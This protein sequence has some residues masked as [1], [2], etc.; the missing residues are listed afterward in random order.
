MNDAAI[1]AIA[2][3]SPF[4]RNEGM[5]TSKPPS[6]ATTPPPSRLTSTGVPSRSSMTATVYAPSPMK[7]A[8]PRLTSPV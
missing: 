4:T 7:A 2:R 1:V 5:P 8:C 3:Y 6:I